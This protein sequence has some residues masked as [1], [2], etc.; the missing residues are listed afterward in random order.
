MSP[1]SALILILAEPD[2]THTETTI[3][4]PP[5]DS[6]PDGA[7]LP[8]TEEYASAAANLRHTKTYNYV[9]VEPSGPAICGAGT[10]VTQGAF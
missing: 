6:V 5:C 10:T 9:P 8:Y 1:E 2:H 7:E 4:I 3:S